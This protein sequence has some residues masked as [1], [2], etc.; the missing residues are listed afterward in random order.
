MILFYLR[1]IREQ[2][3]RSPSRTIISNIWLVIENFCVCARTKRKR[4]NFRN[5]R[6]AGSK[7]MGT[8]EYVIIQSGATSGIV[9]LRFVTHRLS[10]GCD[11]M[12]SGFNFV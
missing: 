12:R 5:E 6:V 11:G 3:G 1:M 7:R 2:S 4:L 8:R 10:N 9:D